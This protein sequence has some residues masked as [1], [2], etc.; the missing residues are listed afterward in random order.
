VIV[1]AVTP[2]ALAVLL[3]GDP[4]PATVVPE[5][6]A[7]DF[8][9]LPHATD[10]VVANAMTATIDAFDVQRPLITRLLC[11]LSDPSPDTDGS[12]G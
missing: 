5:P 2:G 12:F 3:V 11:L 9:L 1:D 10:D 4:A 6:G 8:P 7:V